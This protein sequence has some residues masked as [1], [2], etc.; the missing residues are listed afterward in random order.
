MIAKQPTRIQLPRFELP[1]SVRGELFHKQRD[2]VDVYWGDI[3]FSTT[4]LR[5]YLTDPD[6]LITALNDAL[7]F[8]DKVVSGTFERNETLFKHIP[9]EDVWYSKGLTLPTDGVWERADRSD[10][11]LTVSRRDMRTWEY[12][13]VC[14]YIRLDL[15]EKRLHDAQ[16]NIAEIVER[17]V[18]SGVE[19]AIGEGKATLNQIENERERLEKERA[20]IDGQLEKLKAAE[21]KVKSRRNT[22]PSGYVYLIQSPTGYYKIGRTRNPDDRLATFSIKL[23][24]EVEYKHLIKTDD[25]FTLEAELH[26]RY[27]DCR[28]SGEWFQLSDEQVAEIC[29]NGYREG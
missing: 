13:G 2:F 3:G 10:D 18:R 17:G 23:P 29:S 26:R 4:N 28:V 20:R 11:Y 6:R 14:H 8:Q 1:H 12:T 27:A 24:F 25:M 7:D 9:P 15:H 19:R 16:L 21:E 22:D 5:S